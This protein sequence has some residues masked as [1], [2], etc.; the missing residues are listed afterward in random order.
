MII[1]IM[2]Y[3]FGLISGIILAAVIL[4]DWRSIGKPVDFRNMDD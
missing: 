3:I 4:T 2:A 1:T